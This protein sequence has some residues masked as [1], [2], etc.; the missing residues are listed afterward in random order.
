MKVKE[1]RWWFLLFWVLA[2]YVVKNIF[3]GTNVDEGYAVVMGY[4][5]AMGDKLLLEMWE[6]HQTSAIF[7]AFLMKPFLLVT[8]GETEFLT[9][10]LRA[11]YFLIQG[12]IAWFLYKTLCRCIP[13]IEQRFAVWL[14]LV[15]FVSN[16][17]SIFVPEYSNLHIWFLMLL[18]LCLMWYCCEQSPHRGKTIVLIAAGVCLTCDVLS[19]PSMALL[20]P[21]CIIFILAQR[22][23]HPIKACAALIA[24]CVVSALIFMGYVLTYMTPKQIGQVLP[25]ILG[26]GSHQADLKS[27]LMVC[28]ED[29]GTIGMVV[30]CSLVLAFVSAMLY[31]KIWHKPKERTTIYTLFFFLGFQ[32]V[33]QIWC[34]LFGEYNAAHPRV[35]YLAIMAVGIYC[36]CKR[37]KEEKMGAGLILFSLISYIGAICMSNWGPFVLLPY[38]VVGAIGGL[39]CWSEYLQNHS[40]VKY[41]LAMSV[42]CAVLVIGNVFGFCWLIIGGEAEHATLMEVRGIH[43]HGFR[44]G[45]FSTYM[46]AYRY[47]ENVEQWAEIVPEGS[48]VL[49][50][51]PSQFFY[52]LGDCT[53]ASP[54]TIST[55]TYDETLFAYWEMNPDRY[56]DVVIVESWFGDIRAVDDDGMIMQWL[57]NEYSATEVTDY[58][59]V[60][61]YKH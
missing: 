57:E 61:V 31:K 11:V 34:F 1:K 13:S 33:Y 56:P 4:R 54:N 14:S 50:V 46:D 30:V 24:P 29:F 41:N 32:M 44:A 26:D 47:N 17:K 38:L 53:I 39:I 3:V 12:L 49:Y 55:P 22:I 59:Y 52:M 60:R 5:L 16:P 6:P 36:Y 7:T 9:L 21:V 40:F 43:K 28:A 45:V 23:K 20:V 15:F 35:I 25:H 10:Y 48:T 42:L 37:K 58:S 19:Y 8:G 51:G 2:A 18:C 27:K